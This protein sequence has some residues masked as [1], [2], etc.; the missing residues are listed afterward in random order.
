MKKID[1]TEYFHII[2]ISERFL[3]NKTGEEIRILFEEGKINGKKI[4]TEWY[5]DKEAIDNYIELFM[6]ERFFTIGPSEIDLNTIEMEGRILDIGGGGEGVIGQLKGSQVIAIDP[7]KRELEEAPRNESLNIIMDGKDLK[8]LDNTF[9]SVTAF[10][11]L[12]YIPLK[13]RE[14]VFKEIHRVLKKK[15]EF[16]LWDLIIPPRDGQKEAVYIIALKIRVNEDIINTGYGTRWE[17]DQNADYFLKLGKDV[18]FEVLEE[19][20]AEDTFFIKFR[21]S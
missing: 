11:T 12:M 10:F 2:E 21:K 14:T 3:E 4:E 17:K 20:I 15:G 16:F 7:S 18:V 5:A 13:D 19:K 8:F 6:N 1:N 9:D